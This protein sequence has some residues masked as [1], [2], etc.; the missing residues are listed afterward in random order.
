MCLKFLKHEKTVDT[1]DTQWILNFDYIVTNLR[2][3]SDMHNLLF[4]LFVDC[5]KSPLSP[6]THPLSRDLLMFLIKV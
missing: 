3:C 1:H 5:F 4:T 6:Q 2:N